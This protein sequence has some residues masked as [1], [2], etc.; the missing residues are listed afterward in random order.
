MDGAT[1]EYISQITG[2]SITTL[3]E[4]KGKYNWE[5]QREDK[6]QNIL[7]TA[8]ELRRQL[9]EH[10]VC[11]GKTEDFYSAKGADA[12]LKV[13]QA[14]ERLGGV[15]DLASTSIIVMNKFQKYVNSHP[16]YTTQQK[17]ACFTALQDFLIHVKEEVFG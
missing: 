14:M 17:Q 4:W 2:V 6:R 9:H 15:E 5:N 11:M 16:A 8:E 12:L 1:L 3:S 13:C 10:I 7:N